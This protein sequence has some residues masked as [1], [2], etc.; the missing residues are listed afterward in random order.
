MAKYGLFQSGQRLPMQEFDG[1]YMTQDKQFVHIMER[2]KS[3][4]EVDQQVA[5]LHLDAGQSIKKISD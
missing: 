4:N 3:A 2:A 1:D 5:A